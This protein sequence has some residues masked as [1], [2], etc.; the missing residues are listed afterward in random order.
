MTQF[1]LYDTDSNV[2]LFTK[3]LEHVW[4]SVIGVNA[5]PITQLLDFNDCSEWAVGETVVFDSCC[6]WSTCKDT[7]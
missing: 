2:S 1:D 3:L 4:V 7:N 5:I 6:N